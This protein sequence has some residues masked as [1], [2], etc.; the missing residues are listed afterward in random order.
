MAYKNPKDPRQREANKRWR[1]SHP[2]WWKNKKRRN[3]TTYLREIILDFLIK[4]DGLIC[5]FCKGS[6]EN[7]K[8]HLDHIQPVALGG[9]NTMENIRLAHPACNLKDSHAIRKQ[10]LG[11]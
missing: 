9:P 7:S 6:L 4:R 2:G 5:G 10:A 11:Y 3:N 1:D 8:I